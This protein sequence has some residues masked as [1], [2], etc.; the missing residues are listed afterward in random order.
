M[1][2]DHYGNCPECGVSWD[3]GEIPEKDRECY[4]PPYRF[5]RLIGIEYPH[6]YDGVWEWECPDCKKKFPRFAK[7]VSR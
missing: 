2:M 4:A 1:A 6:R 7:G 3:G 5:S